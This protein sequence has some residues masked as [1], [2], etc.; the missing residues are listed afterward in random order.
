MYVHHFVTIAVSDSVTGSDEKPYWVSYAAEYV[1][2]S[3]IKE[4]SG[5]V[6]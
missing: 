6:P 4:M 1:P 5:N 3:V 2:Q